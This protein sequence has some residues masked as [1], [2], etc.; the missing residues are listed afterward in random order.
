MSASLEGFGVWRAAS[1]LTPGLAAALEELGYTAVWVGGSP[2]A[3]LAIVEQLLDATE[4]ITVATGIVN[5]YRA[6]AWSVAAS[7]HR[8]TDK[9]PG[10]FLLGVG[11]GHP[12]RVGDRY[13]P[14]YDALQRYLDELAAAA[15][16]PEDI[17]LAALGPRVLRL[18]AERTAGAHPYLTT[19]EHTARAREIL[20]R[21]VLLAPEHKVVLTTDPERAR[22]IGRSR[23]ANPYLSLINYTNNLRR[24]GFSDADLADGGS[25]RLLDAL[26]AHGDAKSV[27][28]RL[29]E[30]LDAGADHVAVQLLTATAADDPL[31]GFRE[32]AAALS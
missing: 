16:P 11:V 10:R 1:D 3:D 9:H 20:G 25:D 13:Q 28:A 2:P 12:E 18:A 6:E 26:V 23:V 27:A 32:L 22:E 7:Y 4:S 15:V 5:I 14:P 8:I 19:P 31:P 29:R 30:H 24:L 21:G 17:V